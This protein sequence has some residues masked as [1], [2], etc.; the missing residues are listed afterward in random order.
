MN[1]AQ[2]KARLLSNLNIPT[3]ELL[4]HLNQSTCT[5]SKSIDDWLDEAPL[6]SLPGTLYLPVHYYESV[7]DSLENADT[8]KNT[9]IVPRHLSGTSSSSTRQ[10][11]LCSLPE[12][13]VETSESNGQDEGLQECSKS[14]SKKED[15]DKSTSES[16]YSHSYEE[17]TAVKRLEV[18]ISQLTDMHTDLLLLNNRMAEKVRKQ[19]EEIRLLNEGGRHIIMQ[20]KKLIRA[21]LSKPVLLLK[22]IPIAGHHEYTLNIEIGDDGSPMGETYTLKKRFRDFV[23][24]RTELRD[25][26][27]SQYIEVTQRLAFPP[28][29]NF[30]LTDK[31]ASQ[32]QTKLNAWLAVVLKHSVDGDP[33]FHA[34]PSRDVLSLIFPFL[35]VDYY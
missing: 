6:Y 24:L 9:C 35:A 28:K 31:I 1:R 16:I 23:K 4:T 29:L 21:T 32:R 3:N 25:P 13:V 27:G 19:A 33:V 8:C 11:D 10:A 15:M 22:N 5:T 30:P 14:S 2:L 20:G 17:T 7:K 12:T 34:N 18:R 26:C